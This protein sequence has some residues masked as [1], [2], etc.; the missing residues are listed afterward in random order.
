MYVYKICIYTY[1]PSWTIIPLYCTLYFKQEKSDEYSIC[2]WHVVFNQ[3][4]RTFE[5]RHTLAHYTPYGHT[6]KLVQPTPWWR[7][8]PITDPLIS[9]KAPPARINIG[10]PRGTRLLM[11]RALVGVRPRNDCERVSGPAITFQTLQKVTIVDWVSLLQIPP[12]SPARLLANRLLSH[13]K[14]SV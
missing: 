6:P 10:R 5:D 3:W 14:Y 4:K 1:A 12:E 13:Q 9:P 2:S 8:E 11:R 7:A